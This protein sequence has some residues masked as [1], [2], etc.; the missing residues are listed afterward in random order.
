[1]F[2]HSTK[3]HTMFV[4]MDESGD[5]QFTPKGKQHFILSAV[6]TITPEKSAAAM[7]KLKYDLLASG[8]KDLHFHATENSKGTRRRVADVISSLDNI[9][10]HSI[11]IDKA[12]T[13]PDLQEEVT[14]LK[15]FGQNMG[16]W[17]YNA[18]ADKCNRIILIFDS[19]LTGKKQ[20]ALEKQ[21][22]IALAPLQKEI[23][24][25]F[26][27]VKQDLNGQIADYYSWALFRSLESN[28]HEMKNNLYSGASE[29][30]TFD[31]FKDVDNR[32]WNR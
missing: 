23:R 19:V 24:I 2:S 8:S 12:Y 16:Q 10:I 20:K 18:I 11:W 32:F 22:K 7:Q 17:V 30:D 28:D 4:F 31:L 15:L 29:W 5:L 27:P 9:R 1:M 26:H 6:C 21:L 3:A 25:L 13:Q 14:L